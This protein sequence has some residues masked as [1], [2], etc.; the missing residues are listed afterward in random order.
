L[1]FSHGIGIFLLSFLDL[2]FYWCINGLLGFLAV[3]GFDWDL[4][5][6]VGLGLGQ[7]KIAT[8]LLCLAWD[9]QQ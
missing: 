5:V 6:Q 7:L 3:F 8:S 4:G 9:G 2:L 1:L